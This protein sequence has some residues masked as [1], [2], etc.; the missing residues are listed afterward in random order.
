M[1]TS[2]VAHL[3]VVWCFKG[4]P[5]PARC[6]TVETNAGICGATSRQID[7]D[8]MCH[9]CATS[10]CL[11]CSMPSHADMLWCSLLLQG[12]DFADSGYFRVSA[13]HI[14]HGCSSRYWVTA[15]MLH[16]CH[17]LWSVPDQTEQFVQ[18]A[19]HSC[20]PWVVHWTSGRWFP[21]DSCVDLL[22]CS[23]DSTHTVAV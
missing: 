20:G 22:S 2:T 6:C 23:A 11:E 15:H 5:L 14:S 4:V 17:S 9:C 8:S 3:G 1:W 18:D 21:K 7:P 13:V 10:S 12:S 19:P 16:A